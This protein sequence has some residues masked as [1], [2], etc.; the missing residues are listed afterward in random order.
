[1]WSGYQQFVDNL[2]KTGLMLPKQAPSAY[3]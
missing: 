3:S 1:M 2:R